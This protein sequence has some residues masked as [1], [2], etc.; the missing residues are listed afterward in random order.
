MTVLANKIDAP[1]R[2]IETEDAERF[3]KSKNIKYFEVS[4]KTGE[5]VHTAFHSVAENL[6]KVYPK[7][8]KKAELNPVIDDVR[9]KKNDFHIRS[10]ADK[11]IKSGCC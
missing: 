7:E 6:T 11:K 1:T 4:A 10:G 9:K 2:K 5:N 3:C 8:E